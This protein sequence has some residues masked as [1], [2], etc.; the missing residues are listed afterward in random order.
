MSS[1]TTPITWVNGSV[2]AAQMNA[3]IKDHLNHLK[4]G[5]DLLTNST[6]KDTEDAAGPYLMVSRS[7][8]TYPAFRARYTSFT[9]PSFTIQAGGD[10]YWSFGGSAPTGTIRLT[11]ESSSQLQFTGGSVWVQREG[12]NTVLFAGNVS[13]D[14]LT[15]PRARVMVRTEGGGQFDVGDGTTASLGKFYYDGTNTQVVIDGSAAAGSPAYGVDLYLIATSGKAIAMGRGVST[16]PD[17]K[18]W[19]MATDPQIDLGST[20][21]YHDTS[22]GN[23]VLNTYGQ[24]F[25]NGGIATLY[26]GQTV[27]D[28]DFGQAP[29][30][31]TII[32]DTAKRMLA[33]KTAASTWQAA[34]LYGH[35]ACIGPY[36]VNNPAANSTGDADSVDSWGGLARFSMPFNGHVVAISVRGSGSV[37]TANSQI[38]FRANYAGIA[39]GPTVT[40]APSGADGTLYASTWQDPSGS[41][42]FDNGSTI[43]VTWTTDTD[44]TQTTLDFIVYVWVLQRRG[45]YYA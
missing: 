26:L 20:S 38:A 18:F 3:E 21:I 13:G 43:G 17:I 10:L 14:A 22:S 8:A 2:T 42:A 39:I 23:L 34:D 36:E 15:T 1:W 40:L 5:L 4:G 16:A 25:A 33:V 6:F 37:T 27:Q 41:N 12:V 11:Q 24:V 30:T 31:G 7:Q 9:Y 32:V 45:D 35:L 29:L 44:W 28:G 19:P